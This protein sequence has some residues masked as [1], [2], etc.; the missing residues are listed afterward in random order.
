MAAGVETLPT[1]EVADDTMVA[2]LAEDEVVG[3]VE[4]VSDDVDLP[5]DDVPVEI[6]T[7]EGGGAGEPVINGGTTADDLPRGG[8]AGSGK[9][10]D[11]R[12]GKPPAS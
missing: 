4:D 1:V 9:R 10:T 3:A 8:D 5:V 7:G 6:D 11:K 12:P 2:P